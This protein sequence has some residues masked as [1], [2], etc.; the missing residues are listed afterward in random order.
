MVILAFHQSRS[1]LRLG[2]YIYILGNIIVLVLN[3]F[4]FKGIRLN[5][6]L[7]ANKPCAVRF[8]LHMQFSHFIKINYQ[9]SYKN[10]AV[11]YNIILIICIL[12]PLNLCMCAITVSIRPHI[13]YL[14]GQEQCYPYNS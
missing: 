11:F 4:R 7:R 12:Y 13:I 6:N 14:V 3:A 9:S 1:W 10:K 8:N 5:Y 2:L